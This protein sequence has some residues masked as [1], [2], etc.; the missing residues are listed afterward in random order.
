MPRRAAV[1]KEKPPRPSPKKELVLDTAEDLFDRYGFFGT[2]IDRVIAESGVARMTLYKH[3]PTK[4]ALVRAV[5]ERRDARQWQVIEGEAARRAA[6]GDHPVLALFDGLAL[7]LESYAAQ[8]CLLL[9]A[10]GEYSSH[11]VTVA[12]D[13]AFRK[14]TAAAVFTR[15]LQALGVVAAEARAAQLAL[16]F[17]GAAAMAPVDG[18]ACAAAAAREAAEALLWAWEAVA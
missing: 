13:A 7:W 2:G 6:A 12:G 15:H 4:G 5:L 14:K 8:G 10:L 17:E 11:D 3:F 18:G 9:R 1:L 16:L